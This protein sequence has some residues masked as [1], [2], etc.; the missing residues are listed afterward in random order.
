MSMSHKAGRPNP[1]DDGILF[2]ITKAWGTITKKAE[3]A[4]ER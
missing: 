3:E 4:V 1:D 2:K